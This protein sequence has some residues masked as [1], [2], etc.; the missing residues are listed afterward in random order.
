MY[1]RLLVCKI[2]RSLDNEPEKWGSSKYSIFLGSDIKISTL[3]AKITVTTPI[4]FRFGT[5]NSLRLRYAIRRWKARTIYQTATASIR[6][7][8][9]NLINIKAF[10]LDRPNELK[11]TLI[12]H[13]GVI[14]TEM[15]HNLIDKLAKETIEQINSLLN[16]NKP[17]NQ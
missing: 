17:T 1:E 11:D 9:R 15:A 5:I 3:E 6:P 12:W 7:A 16:N 8:E 2:I 10:L 14:T 13:R 4:I